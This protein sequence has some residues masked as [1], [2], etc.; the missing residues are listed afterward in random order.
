VAPALLEL[1]EASRLAGNALAQIVG[2][3]RAGAR[4][5]GVKNPSVRA[6]CGAVGDHERTAEG[7]E[8]LA[9][10]TPEAAG[11]VL[12]AIVHGAEIEG[13]V[14][15]YMTVVD[16]VAGLV[17]LGAGEGL[18]FAAEEMHPHEARLETCHHDIGI[19][20]ERH[21]AHGLRDL[22]LALMAR[23]RLVAPDR[24]AF[25]VDEEEGAGA[26][27]PQRPF[28]QRAAARDCD[29]GGLGVNRRARHRLSF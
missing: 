20:R 18:G 2:V 15:P 7:V 9:V 1:Q 27:I 23:I 22:D 3:D 25:D 12:P 29:A 6:D 19:L 17:G 10:P 8:R 26:V 5:G 24:P 14:R 4:I 28:A 11:G 21:E 16:A 13:T